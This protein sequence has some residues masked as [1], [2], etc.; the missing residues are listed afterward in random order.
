MSN[1]YSS[2]PKIAIIGMSLCLIFFKQSNPDKYS[3]YENIKNIFTSYSFKI[4]AVNAEKL[5]SQELSMLKVAD[6][7]LRDAGLNEERNLAVILAS[8]NS[9]SSRI[10]AQWNFTGPS[11]TLSTGENSTFKALAIAQMLLAARKVDA[12]LV[13]AVDVAGAVAVVLKRKDSA[14]QNK[15]RIYAVIDAISLLQKHSTYEKLDSGSRNAPLRHYE[16]VRKACQQAFK[17][18]GIQPGDI[19]Y[20]EFLGSGVQQKDESQLKGLVQAYQTSQP[21]LSCAISSVDANIYH[22]QA[23]S[24]IASLIKTTLCLYHRYIPAS[25]QWSSSNSLAFLGLEVWGSPFYIPSESMPW[26]LE[27]GATRRVAAI[28]SIG[29]DGNYAHLILSA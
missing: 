15:N 16:A 7:A 14:K 19:N 2:N 3:I 10:Y 18:A 4:T 12:V 6:N 21:E 28:N 11:L 24:E 8:E 23:A 27:K 5:K 9:I 22:T 20:L 1:E 29:L 13:G 26:F 17:L 25:P